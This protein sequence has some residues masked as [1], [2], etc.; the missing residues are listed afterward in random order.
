MSME[1]DEIN[2]AGFTWQKN[3]WGGIW[4]EMENT[5]HVLLSGKGKVRYGSFFIFYIFMYCF[6]FSNLIHILILWLLNP[7][8]KLCGN[9]YQSNKFFLKI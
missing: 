2:Y 7:R 8:I 9:M 3:N 1:E 5:Q 6:I 4:A